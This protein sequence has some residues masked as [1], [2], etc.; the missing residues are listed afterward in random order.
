MPTLTP[1]GYD[2]HVGVP[3]RCRDGVQ[4]LA[5]VYLPRGR[6]RSPALLQRTP[7]SRDR[8]IVVDGA[9]ALRAAVEAGFAVVV[10][11]VRGRGGSDG[12]FE[13]LVHEAD[14]GF[15][16][17]Q[18]VAAQDWCDGQVEMYG[19]S[20]AGLAQW[21]TAAACPPALRAIAPMMAGSDA[22]RNWFGVGRAFEQGFV[23][24]WVLTSLAAGD[25]RRSGDEEALDRLSTLTAD[26][27]GWR[28]PLSA[29]DRELLGRTL[30]YVGDW[31][32]GPEPLERWL[33]DERLHVDLASVEV[34][35]MM[36]GGWYDFGIGGVL[37][38]YVEL[39]SVAAHPPTLVV[40]PWSHGSFTGSY[41]E[42]DFGPGAGVDGV[43]HSAR[44]LRWLASHLRP[45]PGDAATPPDRGR[46]DLFD[47][48]A[49]SW[50]EIE[51][52]S[53]SATADLVLHGAATS[54][55]LGPDADA[56]TES[57][58]P[59]ILVADVSDPA[60]TVG[61]PVYLPGRLE[62][63][64][65]RDQRALLGRPDVVE[66]PCVGVPRGTQLAGAVVVRLA[67]SAPHTGTRFVAKLCVRHEGTAGKGS[68]MLLREAAVTV[69]VAGDSEVEIAMGYVLHRLGDDER[70]VLLLSNT[71][72]PRYGPSP[73]EGHSTTEQDG[74]IRC[75]VRHVTL[76]LVTQAA[77]VGPTEV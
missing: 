57:A 77:D 33:S 9:I 60:P 46:I 34:P 37:S 69:E 23:T 65:P 10:Q 20:Y 41:A 24:A 35:V 76:G 16:A 12:R 31:L 55:R 11:D 32:G 25:L 38:T 63:S 47:T 74:P 48:G 67:V 21:L 70:L 75:A 45:V 6:A 4:L 56:T 62:R 50:A 73:V 71:S 49:R 15:D 36:T 53:L 59:L 43:G 66:L 28:R 26:P 19:R 22:G 8:S 40:G 3:M 52:H 5:D 2:V 61:G 27:D 1:P 51:P 29:A 72:A 58:A 68:T 13:P 14:D 54:D 17:V 44:Q 18:W 30:G 39:R 7:Y 64:G 42:H